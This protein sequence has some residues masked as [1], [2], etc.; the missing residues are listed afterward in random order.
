MK[1]TNVSGLKVDDHLL[2]FINDEAIPDTG[3]SIKNFW[4]GFSKTTH[5]LSPINKKLLEK[6]DQIQK[7][8]R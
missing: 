4:D 1:K 5:E 2:K 8:N 6:R 7:K 3:I